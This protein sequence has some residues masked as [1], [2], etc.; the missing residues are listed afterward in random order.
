LKIAVIGTGYWGSK[1]LATC[2]DVSNSV[3]YD[4]NDNWNS[5]NFD[6]AVICTPAETHFEVAKTCLEMG[7]NVLIEK[8]VADNKAN[9]DKLCNLALSKNLILQSG[10]ILLFTETTRYIKEQ[11]SADDIKFIQTRRCNFGNIPRKQI[12]LAMHLLVHDLALVDYLKPETITDTKTT[13]S[14][15]LNTN[16][17]DNTQTHINW[18][19]FSSSHEC[20]W[21]YPVKTRS[22]VVQTS[23]D[24]LYCDDNNNTV[25][26]KNANYTERLELISDNT[27]ILQDK[28]S[29][30]HREIHNFL[31]CVNT[32]NQQGCNGIDHVQRVYN[33]LYTN[34]L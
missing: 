21:F 7:K 15:I 3:G 9:V 33:N 5:G 14:D 11:I 6:V 17:Y 30:M 34:I 29:P 13:G 10:H 19:T 2:R 23:T 4:V 27:I 1:V 8:P 20:S 26:H 32:G 12:D 18:Q 28:S 31:D 16:Y 25:I 24:L 22:V